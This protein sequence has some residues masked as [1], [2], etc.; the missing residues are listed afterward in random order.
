MPSADLARYCRVSAAWPQDK[1][2]T[3]TSWSVHVILAGHPD[4]F[5]LINQPPLGS[6][7][8]WTC[9]AARTAIRSP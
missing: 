5:D 8:G 9:E 3:R 1:R 7:P 4:R 6:K 2:D